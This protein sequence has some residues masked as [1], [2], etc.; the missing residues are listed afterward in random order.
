[1]L[2]LAVEAGC[3]PT[4]FHVDHGLRSG[5]SAEAE[6]VARAASALGCAFVALTVSCESGPNLEARARAA[7]LSVLPPDVA[8]GHTADDQAETVLL[9]LLRGSG[10]D[11]VS[12]MRPGPRHPILALRRSETTAIARASGLEIV[13]DPSNDDPAFRRNRVR[14][15]LI[16]LMDAIAGRDV[17]PL[18]AR[19]AELAG[20]DVELLESLAADVDATSVAH[21]RAVPV[22][23]RRRVIRR[24]VRQARSTPYAPD[25]ATVARVLDVI[26]GTA[27]RA[28]IG[29]GFAIGRRRGRLGIEP[30]TETR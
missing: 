18:L 23:T 7:R 14:H 8:T 15:E 3:R 1:M 29:G 17:V 21:L 19:F 16:P 9:N 27:R 6:V 24:L 11:G 20:D 13:V 30:P 28:E 12:G 2:I 4:A 26:D 22:P 10:I 5:S 25:V